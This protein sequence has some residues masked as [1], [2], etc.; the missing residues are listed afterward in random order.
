[1]KNTPTPNRAAC[2]IRVSTDMQLEYSP[3]SQLRLIRD[4]AEKNHLTLLDEHIYEE[5]GISG[6][7]AAKR[8]AFLS[9]IA[10]A[11]Q[12]LFDVILIY[13]SNR[14]ARNHEESIVYKSMLK[15]DCGVDLISITQPPVDRK[16]DM[17]TGAIYAVM[18]E[19]FECVKLRPTTF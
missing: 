1:M 12:H 17:L 10:A 8:P 18:D 14:F 9:M 19:W 7:N 4:Y 16:T 5:L 15:R 3:A 6:K 2:Y 11:K 13:H